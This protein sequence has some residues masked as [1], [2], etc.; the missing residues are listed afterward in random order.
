MTLAALDD[1]EPTSDCA[2]SLPPR[3][4]RHGDQDRRIVRVTA[5]QRQV[6]GGAAPL[7]A[8]PRGDG[9]FECSLSLDTGQRQRHGQRHALLDRSG[10]DAA[11]H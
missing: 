8:I 7:V 10:S 11:V 4:Q 3:C 2:A 9:A 5:V 6:L 1:N